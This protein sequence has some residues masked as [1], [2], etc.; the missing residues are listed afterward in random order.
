VPGKSRTG[1]AWP[2]RAEGACLLTPVFQNDFDSVSPNSRGRTTLM[3]FL[4]SDGLM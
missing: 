2:A 4:N 1:S 3:L